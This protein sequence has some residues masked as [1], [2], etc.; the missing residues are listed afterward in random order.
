[1]K[2]EL[3]NIKVSDLVDGYA[4]N[5]EG[6]VVGYHGQLNIRPK[7]QREFIYSPEQE[8]AVIRT[9]MHG[10]PLNTMY[11][12]ALNGGQY[13][14]MDGQQRTLSICQYISGD[15]SVDFGDGNPKNFFNLKNDEKA[16][17]MDY[18][19]T[20]YFCSG[21]DN[22]KLDWF[23]TVNIAGE[24]LTDQ[25]LRN[26]VY[27]GPWTTDAKRYFSKTGCAAAKLGGDYITGSPIRQ[28]LLEKVL[29]W[30]SAPLGL[31]I[32]LYMSAHQN[33]VNAKAEWNYFQDVISWIEGT[34]EKR[35][36]LMKG[37]DWGRLYNEHKSDVLDKAVLEKRISE[38]LQDDE[39][40]NQKGVYEYVLTGKE[41]F[42]NLRSFDK[43]DMRRKYEEQQGIC[44]ICGKHYEIEEMEGDHITPWSQ[45]GKTEYSNLQMLCKKCNRE[46]SNH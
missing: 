23:Q 42:L 25:E 29:K 30:I 22:E 28:E 14:V 35:T 17:I 19:L 39:V 2:I 24:K 5:Q 6:G 45:G 34:F 12:I 43:R 36:K 8:A 40:T 9:V 11:W 27:A 20:V 10:F 7:Y 13:E 37:L 32:K 3:Q 21:T 31:S 46:K 33:D 26:A 44:P 1:M 41:K 15:F 18:G 38:L 16:K 4:D